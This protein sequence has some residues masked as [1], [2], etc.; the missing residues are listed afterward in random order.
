MLIPV[1]VTDRNAHSRHAG[2]TSVAYLAQSHTPQAPE[3]PRGE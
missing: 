3:A 1:L 2:G